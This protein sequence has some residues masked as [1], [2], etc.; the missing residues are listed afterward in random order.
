[1]KRHKWFAVLA[2]MALVFTAFGCKTETEQK[3]KTY[4]SAVTFTS[5][6]IEDRVKITM[7]TATE[8]AKIYYTTDGTAPTS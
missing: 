2:A 8:D 5:Q 3:D 1:M 4:C 7:A 6:A